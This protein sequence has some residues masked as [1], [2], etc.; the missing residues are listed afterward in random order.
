M[1]GPPHG[2]YHYSLLLSG[3]Q[4][5]LAP[6]YDVASALAYDDRYPPKLRMAMKIGGEYRVEATTGRHWRKPDRITER[7]STAAQRCRVRLRH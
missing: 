3:P 5:R 4:V 7:I 2:F 6:M 1:G